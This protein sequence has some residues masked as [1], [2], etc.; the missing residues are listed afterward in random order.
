M[1]MVAARPSRKIRNIRQPIKFPIQF[2]P[3]VS[4]LHVRMDPICF[5]G[6]PPTVLSFIG[7]DPR[8]D[9]APLKPH[10]HVSR[11]AAPGRPCYHTPRLPPWRDVVAS[12]PH[13][14]SIKVLQSSGNANGESWVQMGSGQVGSI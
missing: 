11:R 1:L 13:R 14:A 12:S 7:P 4:L 10:V 9:A 6:P 8:A 3:Q 2:C 5:A